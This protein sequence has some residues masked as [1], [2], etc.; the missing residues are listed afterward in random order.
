MSGSVTIPFPLVLL[1]T[2]AFGESGRLSTWQKDEDTH[3]E[4]TL[5]AWT[6]RGKAF[7]ENYPNWKRVI[8]ERNDTTHHV[9]FQDDRAEKLQRYLKSIPDDKE[10]NNSVKLSRL[11]E[12]PDNL[13]LE[14]SNGMLFSILAEFDPNWG[15]LSFSVRKEFLLRLL[16]A[17]HRKIELND[18]FSPLVGTGGTG[19]YIAMPL[20]FKNPKPQTMQTVEQ[21]EAQPEQTISAEA[22]T[23]TE[24]KPEQTAPQPVP[25]PTESVPEQIPLHP[26]ETEPQNNITNT[27]TSIKEKTTM[28]TN[29]ITHT[30][31][32]PVQTSA[33][34]REPEKEMNPLDELL[35]NIE[36]MKAK[37]KVMF[38]DSAAMARKVRVLSV[39]RSA[40]TSRPGVPSS[41]SAPPAASDSEPEIVP[42]LLLTPILRTC[43]SLYA[44]LLHYSQQ[45]ERG[46]L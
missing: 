19:Q 20:Y 27:T 32:A 36:D 17:G 8:P 44:K 11:P 31:S 41:A 4:L 2:K 45:N 33:Q 38:D 22:D 21:A 12:V 6:W 29:N 35:A 14:S 18:S 9:S 24:V 42:L 30:V 25:K 7:K 46:Q 16:D 5:G 34:N 26:Q 37:I 39:R 10:R 3:F 1:A 23:K 15:D 28:E 13:H 43:L 40:S